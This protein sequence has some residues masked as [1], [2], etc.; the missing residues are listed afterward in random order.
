MLVRFAAGS[1]L[2]A[3]F[4]AVFLGPAAAT[5]TPT[6]APTP[7]PIVVPTLPPQTDA[8]TQAIIRAAAGI[9]SD[10]IVRNR[11]NAANTTQGIVS[12]FKR[13]DMQVETGPNSYRTVRLHQGTVIN[14]RGATPGT[15]TAVDVSGRGAPDGALD[16]DTITVLR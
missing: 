9:L 1:L 12:Y 10:I 2:A 11:L 6:P 7:S 13:Y 8:A 14:P 15:G 4:G 3:F 16:A 5:A